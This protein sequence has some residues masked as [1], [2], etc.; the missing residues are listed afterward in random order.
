M[1]FTITIFAFA[2]II[3]LFL[4]VPIGV[5][6]GLSTLI[7]MWL[8]G[9]SS[10]EV[11]IAQKMNTGVSSF[12]LLAIP[13]FILSGIFMTRGGIA[14]R[15]LDFA[16]MLI[17]WLPGGISYV[18]ILSSMFFGSISG[19]AVAAISSIG[20]L[21]IPEMSARKYDRGYSGALTTASSITGLLIPPSNVMIVYSLVA[22]GVSITHLFMAGVIPGIVLGLSLCI[23][24]GFI[25]AVKGYGR[26]ENNQNQPKN[27]KNQRQ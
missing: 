4:K 7:G 1:D 21:M 13:F 9:I 2:F 22:G 17:G 5:S 23:V 8:R 3:L 16:S 26:L 25:C 12:A 18:L 14:K 27:K 20:G 19:S 10:S 24:N 11:I 6:I 15:L